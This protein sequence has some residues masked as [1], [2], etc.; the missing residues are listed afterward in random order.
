M[1]KRLTIILMI[2]VIIACLFAVDF[3]TELDASARVETFMVKQ[4]SAVKFGGTFIQWWLF[5]LGW[6]KMA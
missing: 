5:G 1:A 4:N 3:R 6:R 2:F